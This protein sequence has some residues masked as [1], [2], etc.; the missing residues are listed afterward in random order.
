MKQFTPMA[1]IRLSSNENLK[2]LMDL[3]EIPGELNWENAEKLD[4]MDFVAAQK[5]DASRKI[6]SALREIHFFGNHPFA[7]DT[8]RKQAELSG[9]TLPA[10]FEKTGLRYDYA[11]QL[12]LYNEKV[13]HDTIRF[14]KA[15]CTPAR[16]WKFI[17]DIEIPVVK[18]DKKSIDRLSR[19]ISAFFFQHLTC[20]Q[21]FEV[22]YRLRSP[23]VHYFF[24]N[25]KALAGRYEHWNDDNHLVRKDECHSIPVILTCDENKREIA[26]YAEGG[27]EITMPLLRFF[28]K[29]ILGIALPE[30]NTTVRNNID[31]MKYSGFEFVFDFDSG[32]ESV[33]CREM[34][35]GIIGRPGKYIRI[36]V[37]ENGP[38][39]EIA[40]SLASDLD[41][42]QLPLDLLIVR[43]VYV[44][45][46][47][48]NDPRGNGFY[49][50]ITPMNDPLRK[51]PEGKRFIC[52]RL[53]K[54][55][56]IHDR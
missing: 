4:I 40:K 44:Q 46:K 16:S 29:I 42:E 11:I 19:V 22:S 13:W 33:K 34:T 45:V 31:Q 26:A 10:D 54:E 50:Y 49:L 51:L 3:L 38:A 6:H 23:G 14:L 5:A 27:S 12:R 1:V 41:G 35:V 32:I 56:R 20:G 8:A 43:N 53:L 2:A 9:L 52:E 39:D 15:D 48:K 25:F 55:S 37:P 18:T 24:M 36:R 7:K 21:H 17:P 30:A 47:M 28:A